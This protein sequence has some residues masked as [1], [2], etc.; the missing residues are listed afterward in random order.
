M[1]TNRFTGGAPEV[2][3]VEHG[4]PVYIAVG[5]ILRVYF[6][7]AP[8][9]YIEYTCQS[10]SLPD[11]VTA[12]AELWNAST[13][14][15]FMEVTA[16][17]SGNLL[18]LTAII[19]GKPFGPVLVRASG[20]V[21]RTHAK[22]AVQTVGLP[23][24]STGGTFVL[25]FENRATAPLSC[26]AS[27]GEIETA[28]EV[29]TGPDSVNVLDLGDNTFRIE[30][31]NTLGFQYVSPLTAIGS[32]ITSGAIVV[33]RFQA[34]SAGV[35]AIHTVTHPT[36]AVGGTWRLSLGGQ[37][38]TAIPWD[39]NAA[40][41]EAAL[42]A[43]PNIGP[44]DVTVA[45]SGP[46]V[47][48]WQGNMACRPLDP[49]TI[50]MLV[51]TGS[52]TPSTIRQGISGGDETQSY[53]ISPPATQGTYTVAFRGSTSESID[54]DANAATVQTILEAVPT[55]DL[56]NV[57]VT[58]TSGKYWLA[59]QGDLGSCDLPDV[60]IN[61]SMT[62]A[63]LIDVTTPIPGYGANE[64]QTMVFSGANGGTYTLSFGGYTTPV[65]E[66][67]DLY[68]G[69]IIGIR[70]RNLPSIG[71][72]PSVRLSCDALLTEGMYTLSFAGSM[73]GRPW[74]LI[75]ATSHLTLSSATGFVPGTTTQGVDGIQAEI[76]AAITGASSGQVDVRRAVGGVPYGD[77][78]TILYNDTAANC[79]TMVNAI[80]DPITWTA[81]G[82]PLNTAPVVLTA[83]EVGVVLTIEE[84][85]SGGLVWVDDNIVGGDGYAQTTE[86]GTADVN[87]V[88]T[89]T[90]TT[91][92]NTGSFTLCFSLGGNQ[93]TAPLYHNVKAAQI[94]AAL[95]ALSNIE[96]GDITVTGWSGNW[97][98]TFGGTLAATPV[99]ELSI[100]S[101]T[102]L[103]YTISAGTITIEETTEGGGINEVQLVKSAGEPYVGT[104]SLTFGGQTTSDL[105]WNCNVAQ[106]QAEL[107]SLP[108]IG[109]GNAVVSGPGTIFHGFQITFT[110]NEGNQAQADLVANA[111]MAGLLSIATTTEVRGISGRNTKQTVTRPTAATGGTY[112]LVVMVNA[113]FYTTAPIGWHASATEVQAA[114]N[115]LPVFTANDVLVTSPNSRSWAVD[116]G[117]VLSGLNVPEMTALNGLTGEA[118]LCTVAQVVFGVDGVDE[119]QTI[120]VLNATAG[121]WFL[122]MDG[123]GTPGGTDWNNNIPLAYNAS[124][125]DIEAR[126]AAFPMSRTATVTKIVSG[127]STAYVCRFTGKDAR[128]LQPLLTAW[129]YL[130]HLYYYPTAQYPPLS[131]V[132]GGVVTRI[133]QGGPATDDQQV[134][135]VTAAGG[136]Y[137]LAFG[138]TA[139]IYYTA[140]SIAYNANAATIRTEL[141]AL[142]N[143]AGTGNVQVADYPTYIWYIDNA[144]GGTGSLIS[145]PGDSGFLITFQGTL[146]GIDQPDLQHID[147]DLQAP[148][149]EIRPSITRV[150]VP[151]SDTTHEVNI[152]EF[153]NGNGM[154]TYFPYPANLEGHPPIGNLV[155]SLGVYFLDTAE[156][157]QAR[158]NED[159]DA[160]GNVIISGG[161]AGVS[162]LYFK[163]QNLY[164]NW[165]W[166]A[167]VWAPPF[168]GQ[169]GWYWFPTLWSGAGASSVQVSLALR[170]SATITQQQTLI[171]SERPSYT[172]PT[173]GTYTL[174]FN[175]RTTPGLNWNASSGQI[176]T[177]LEQLASVGG[178]NVTVVGN[179]A[180][181]DP[182]VEFNADHL[183]I[184]I[185][186]IPLI[187]AHS[188]LPS[189]TVV[190]RITIAELVKGAAI[191]TEVQTL[192][193]S[194][195][196]SGAFKLV[197]EGNIA[198]MIP[199][200]A[201][202][203][204]A[205]YQAGDI[206]DIL[207][208]YYTGSNGRADIASVTGDNGGP[209]TITWDAGSVVAPLG[210]N[211]YG[212]SAPQPTLNVALDARGSKGTNS[213]QS[214]TLAAEATGGT[215]TITVLGATTSGLAC[216]ASAASVQDALA[217]LTPVGSTGTL[218]ALSGRTYT[219]TFVGILASRALAPI[220]A[221]SRGLVTAAYAPLVAVTQTGMTANNEQQLL[222]P[223]P[224]MTSGTWTIEFNGQT[225]DTLDF[226]AS[227]AEIRS[228]LA[229]SHGFGNFVVS[230]GPLPG[231][232]VALEFT[233]AYAKANQAEVVVVSDVL[234]MLPVTSIAVSPTRLGE[235]A[236]NE[237]QTFT[238]PVGI[239][240][241]AFQLYFADTD[242]VYLPWNA[243]AAQLQEAMVTI[244]GT[245]NFVAV[246]GPLNVAPITGTFTGAYGNQG[247][248][249]IIAL[250]EVG[251]RQSTAI[252]ITQTAIGDGGTTIVFETA[253]ENQ[254]PNDWIDGLNWSL[255]R[256][257]QA[258][259]DLE[260]WQTT[261]HLRWNLPQDNTRFGTI[262][263]WKSATGD[264]G[265]PDIDRTRFESY[266]Q[267]RDTVL[268]ISADEWRF[269]VGEGRGSQF[270]RI[271]IG[272]SPLVVVE[273]TGLPQT[274]LRALMLSGGDD[275]VVRLDGGSVGL[276]MHSDELMSIAA[277]YTSGNVNLYVGDG[278]AL[279][280]VVFNG[281]TAHFYAGYTSMIVWSGVIYQYDGAPGDVT[282]KAKTY[283]YYSTPENGGDFVVDPKAK[284]D[285]RRGTEAVTIDSL[286]GGGVKI[287]PLGRCTV[288]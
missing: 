216:N 15:I 24:T 138:G 43:L 271:D 137:S 29:A 242:S 175:D 108:T 210:F 50:S 155:N 263:Q 45:G 115:A 104:F 23:H 159:T 193:L 91:A 274:N 164:G 130:G 5:T 180:Y 214:V 279:G 219:I 187:Q 114:L 148:V 131:N 153:H 230:R 101:A 235:V 225:T 56:N 14:P 58:V 70:L 4:T 211:H 33:G 192:A 287:D 167:G 99:P 165:Y 113:A 278:V 98:V 11:C 190:P 195:G 66:L 160:V 61:S 157:L 8:S 141:A 267:Y 49:S 67:P 185:Q 12:L 252:T 233:G 282:L 241:G 264:I 60:V 269:G 244:I 39:A 220:T 188:Y 18:I 196:C 275:T 205:P 125:A 262:T 266:A 245:G 260:F 63:M 179:A 243:T 96:A 229:L 69:T 111:S 170:G 100:E 226:D 112:Q 202:G 182:L 218:V 44:S 92:P 72:S 71:N 123:V 145:R 19:L 285:F 78:Y 57:V 36:T 85:L 181:Q 150:G 194:S 258:G 261:A 172:T 37:V 68:A 255:G 118:N 1:P 40:T 215:W 127:L 41:V 48:N 105:E 173:A 280:S 74:P 254:G 31:V 223:T 32:L 81:E 75:T 54:W 251:V 6:R 253:V 140:T 102:T 250:G 286:T 281:G 212:F 276:A 183:G 34:G 171:F 107:D 17:V 228:A 129:D 95:E 237:V 240:G 217:V 144:P 169:G 13:D 154:L 135:M 283:F 162:P 89:L 231:S 136:T 42:I 239:L 178:G 116:F 21:D 25:A 273:G 20:T 191:R 83:D 80:Y 256:A 149:I 213:S 53:A 86:N 97:I 128:K 84:M 62:G 16:S 209:F 270:M 28:L 109:T 120:W 246:G 64:V 163:F 236:G 47:L 227:N 52:I 249:Y 158:I 124:A 206:Q 122:R 26:Y 222:T 221:S 121:N 106:V 117:G 186:S 87:E 77:T 207:E 208:I 38:T 55:I 161:P 200:N 272:D 142:T 152:V 126:I 259:D 132:A 184:P 35:S 59:F 284:F 65:L 247:Q 7:D 93:L 76:T 10:A 224:N 103:A 201:G 288:G 88:Q 168:Y 51:G 265:L 232:A 133:T 73:G 174:S 277:L 27:A 197:P 82:G 143:I 248:A 22:N 9:H 2:A 156:I 30:F 176:Q 268:R 199:G 234:G 139:S 238:A 257:P 3:Q 151:G 46:Y 119:Q 198:N 94:K 79:R 146:A 134:M 166:A 203:I 189:T 90:W 177:M 147:T 110:A 204:A